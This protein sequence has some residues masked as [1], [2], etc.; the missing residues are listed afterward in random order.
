M[1]SRFSFNYN[2]WYV[3]NRIA[4][5]LTYT[6]LPIHSLWYWSRI[7][8]SEAIW[9]IVYW[10]FQAGPGLKITQCIINK[11]PVRG[12]S[13]HC[14]RD[15]LVL[16]CFLDDVLHCSNWTLNMFTLGIFFVKFICNTNNESKHT[17]LCVFRY[18]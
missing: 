14:T 11:Q 13:R 2:K 8:I 17:S 5:L 6:T 18:S 4:I 3:W 7:G 15:S 10:K 12:S 1:F 16:L 9:H